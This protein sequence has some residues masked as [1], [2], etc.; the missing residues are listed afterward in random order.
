MKTNINYLAIFLLS[1]VCT[2]GGCASN[3]DSSRAFLYEEQPCVEKCD[4]SDDLTIPE[5]FSLVK[6]VNN[7]VFSSN[8]IHIAENSKFSIDF[9]RINPGWIHSGKKR[10]KEK[11]RSLEEVVATSKITSTEEN[12]LKGKEMWILTTI[13]S[14]DVT[15]PLESNSKIYYKASSIKLDAESFTNIPIDISE[16]RVFTHSSDSSYRLD[17]RLLEVDNIKIKQE[18]K[19]FQGS[20]GFEGILMAF[21]KTAKKLTGA[22]AGNFIDTRLTQ[23][24]S[25]PLAFER[26]LLNAGSTVEFQASVIISRR[27][28]FKDRY[29]YKEVPILGFNSIKS[30]IEKSINGSQKTK[31]GGANNEEQQDPDPFLAKRNFLLADMVEPAKHNY[32][33][34]LPEVKSFKT[35][36]EH[37]S[38]RDGIDKCLSLVEST[39]EKTRRKKCLNVSKGPYIWFS[40][41]EIEDPSIAL[42]GGKSPIPNVEKQIE[43]L[44]EEIGKAIPPEITELEDEIKQI[45]ATIENWEMEINSLNASINAIM[46]EK[47]SLNTLTESEESEANEDKT[48]SLRELKKTRTDKAEEL[49]AYLATLKF[50]LETEEQNLAQDGMTF[51]TQSILSQYYEAKRG[52]LERYLAQVRVPSD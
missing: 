39:I 28:K 38:F 8:P 24:A 21:Y 41:S 23:A 6:D 11:S 29:K 52:K 20:G 7:L 34:T 31:N 5:S 51:D 43:V 47:G 44:D 2:I 12:H 19:R 48:T 22:I 25:Q 15:D 46:K 36:E 33:N 13:R 17:V 18:L 27:G 1:S 35:P 4:V 50:K 3:V 26:L 32:N 40:V 30:K 45:E 49:K 37:L 10:K 16:S 9:Q 14:L 42:G